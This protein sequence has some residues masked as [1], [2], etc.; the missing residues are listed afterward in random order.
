MSH[1]LVNAQEGSIENGVIR[2]SPSSQKPGILDLQWRPAPDAPWEV[3]NNIVPIAFRG[4]LWG[5]AEMQEG[6]PHISDVTMLGNSTI[7][8]VRYEYPA[9]SNV[10]NVVKEPCNDA[11]IDLVV[12]MSDGPMIRTQLYGRNDLAQVAINN[13]WGFK[14]R[15]DAL[16]IGA[17]VVNIAEPQWWQGVEHDYYQK[18]KFTRLPNPGTA[19]AFWGTAGPIQ[20]QRV[21]AGSGEVVLEVRRAP[22]DPSQ[23]PINQEPWLEMVSV[24]RPQFHDGD[25]TWFGFNAR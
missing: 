24:E 23:G 21:P 15:V 2:L 6:V 14:Y 17:G 1:P 10:N 7:A 19:I 4:G 8:R 3:Y 13:Y 22:W 11:A 18:G 16:D 12:E 20:W 9:F 25:E 5:N